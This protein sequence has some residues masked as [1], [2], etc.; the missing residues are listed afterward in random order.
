MLIVDYGTGVRISIPTTVLATM[1]TGARDEILFKQGRAI[2]ELARVDTIV[3]DK[4]GTL[5][6]GHPGVTDV[7]PEP[8]FD[9]DEVIRLAA[10][11][12]GHLPHP[13]A[14][15]IRRYARRRELELPEPQTVRYQ[16]GGG[17]IATVQGKS[18]LVGDRRLLELHGVHVPPRELSDSSVA[19][20]A[21]N[22]ELALRFR[23]QDKVRDAAR[24]LISDLRGAAG[25]VARQLGLDAFHARLMPEE[26][27]AF[28]T[29]L[30]AEGGYVALVGDGI[31]DAAAMAAANVGIAMPRGADLAREAADVVLL[32]D[33][34]RTL[35]RAV[36]LSRSAMA[37]VRQNIGLVAA[38]NSVGMAL[39]VAGRLNPLTATVVNNGSTLLA[40]VNALRPLRDRTGY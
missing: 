5:T 13:I 30:R 38:P 21:I 39:A 29:S 12:E 36:Q 20:V 25:A 24:Q 23:L 18:V 10:A 22:G 40:E 11:A 26:K 27:A 28:V 31:N 6:T 33:D 4:T 1:I 14:R 32:G 35:L 2:E 34:L 15:A 37:I 16:R 17:V 19:L 9:A 8:A 7:L 3:F